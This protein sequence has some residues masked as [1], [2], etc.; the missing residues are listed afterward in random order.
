MGRAQGGA[1]EHRQP[2]RLLLALDGPSGWGDAVVSTGTS[3]LGVVWKLPVRWSCPGLRPVIGFDGV[4]ARKRGGRQN[5]RDAG[6]TIADRGGG[7]GR[8]DGRAALL[9]GERH[10]ALVDR[11]GI[12]AHG[13]VQRHVLSSSFA[14]FGGDP[15]AKKCR[16][17]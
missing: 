4:R 7:G 5:I 11:A 3:G 2:V 13:G 8:A 15:E 12:T 1:T 9:D 14:H 16:L 17:P 10:G 6:G